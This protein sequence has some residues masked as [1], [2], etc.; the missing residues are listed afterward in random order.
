MYGEV[1]EEQDVAGARGAGSGFGYRVL[2][3][4]KMM[5]AIME[6][7]QTSAFVAAG[8]DANAS[9]FEWGVIKMDDRRD[10]GIAL[11]REVMDVLVHRERGT[12]FRWFDEQLG[13]MQ[14]HI[15]TDE[16]GDPVRQ[17]W[18]IDQSREGGTLELDVVTVEQLAWQVRDLPH[19]MLQEALDDSVPLPAEKFSLRWCEHALGKNVAVVG[20]ERALS[21]TQ[22]ECFFFADHSRC[23]GIVRKYTAPSGHRHAVS[24][25]A[26][27][28][29]ASIFF[30]TYSIYKK[31]KL[32]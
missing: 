2:V 28:G 20:V 16:I 4:G 6:V 12:C 7:L 31:G 24:S 9:T 32:P 27:A 5:A 19:V 8:N 29:R 3:D 15:G 21:G 22:A 17:P 10:H 25:I 18:V 14:L 30:H 1:A 26:L 23:P 13:V 11:V